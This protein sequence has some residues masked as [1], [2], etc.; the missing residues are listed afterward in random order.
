MTVNNYTCIMH[1]T[2]YITSKHKTSTNQPIFM[3]FGLYI[4]SI[5]NI[6]SI[7]VYP[8]NSFWITFMETCII[9]VFTDQCRNG[10]ERTINK[11]STSIIYAMKCQFNFTVIVL[12]L[13]AKYSIFQ[14]LLCV[15]C[16]Y[17]KWKYYDWIFFYMNK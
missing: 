4:I 2:Q 11:L 5:L 12:S 10:Q 1:I 9:N 3:G 13:I 7:S 6:S 17:R 8:K 14:F 16:M 15:M